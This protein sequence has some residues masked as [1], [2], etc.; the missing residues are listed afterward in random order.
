MTDNR[1]CDIEAFLDTIPQYA[2][3]SG[4]V[5]AGALLEE[6]GHPEKA[7]K[8]I[9]VAGSNGKGS[10]CAYLNS[11]FI[12]HGF[13]TGLFTSPHLV[14][15]RE[16][17]RID[18]EMVSKSDF[19]Q[20]FDTVRNAAERLQKKNITLAYFDWLFGMAMLIFVQKQTDF[21]ILET[22]L[23][24]RL[25]A[26]NA[27][28]K[29]VLSVITTISLEHTAVLG[30]T[31][32]QIAKEKAGILKQGVP[33]VY[34][35]KEPEVIAVM[36]HTAQ[37][38]GV[39][40]LI[41]VAPKD[42]QI[43]KNTGKCI[44]FSLHNGYYKNDCFSLSTGA[45]YQ[46]ENC[47]LALTAAAVLQKDGIL[48]LDEGKVRQAVFKTCWEGRMEETEPD[49]YIDG[50]HNPEGIAAFIESARSICGN[51][52]AVL[53]FSVVK[54][55]N[56]EQMIR[57]LTASGIFTHYIIVQMQTDRHLAGESLE[58]LFAR[59]TQA[60]LTEFDKSF[61][62][63]LYGKKLQEEIPDSVLFCTGSLYL[64]GEIKQKLQGGR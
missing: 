2:G 30:D 25:D 21:V 37:T 42:Y 27:V 41:P 13:K 56:F 51:Q 45:V 26:T 16:R 17:I 23:G 54:D 4:V 3:E 48:R 34:S 19:V 59:Y 14:D 35:A 12:Q 29:P 46:A 53:L 32:S 44:D 58:E 40:A 5:R 64:A 62:G 11:I 1:Y 50:A 43:I 28:E 47:S 57:M 60:P 31:L 33:A 15:V 38:A 63:Y 6:L 20:A 55:K 52:P 8:I 24:G 36:E 39:S 18:N 22:G 7:L 49:I 9:H 61:D 10:V